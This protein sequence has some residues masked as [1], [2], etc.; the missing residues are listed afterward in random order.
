MRIT[1]QQRKKEIA[2]LFAK[3]RRHGKNKFLRLINNPPPDFLSASQDESVLV[4]IDSKVTAITS[5]SSRMFSLWSLVLGIK[6]AEA[7]VLN[8]PQ[9]LSQHNATAGTSLQAAAV[10]V[11]WQTNTSTPS[12]NVSNDI[13]YHCDANLGIGINGDS[14][15]GAVAGTPNFRSTVQYTFGSRGTGV[16]YDFP[17]PRCFISRVYT[18]ITRGHTFTF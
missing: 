9:T 13:L 4:R 15:Y 7:L 3:S 1:A 10:E 8:S 18:L 11:L 12:L 14:C 17:L 16:R 2:S 5:A 6:A